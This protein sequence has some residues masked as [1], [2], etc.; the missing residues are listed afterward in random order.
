MGFGIPAAI[1]AGIATGERAVA[2]TGDGGL[3]IVGLELLTAVRERV[4]LTVIVLVDGYLGLIRVSQRART[5]RE[6]GVDISVPDLELFARVGR[7]RTTRARRLARDRRRPR[8]RARI[9]RR[10][11]RRGADRRPSGSRTTDSSRP[12]AVGRAQGALGPVARRVELRWPG[13]RVRDGRR[14]RGGA[15]RSATTCPIGAS[16]PRSSSR[17]RSRSRCCSRARPAS[18]RRRPR[19]RSPVRWTPA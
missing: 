2:V 16:R 17:R 12:C 19:R 3:D 9:R 10:H 13:E 8:R 7:C 5:G 6:A 4:P 18:G 11:R 15:S 14:A 1:G